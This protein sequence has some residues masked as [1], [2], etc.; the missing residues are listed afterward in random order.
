MRVALHEVL[1]DG[2]SYRHL[3]AAWGVPKSTIFRSATGEQP[4]DP[5]LYKY[6]GFSVQKTGDVDVAGLRAVA[7]QRGSDK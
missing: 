3:E 7:H 4:V 2:F 5:R 1:A 6:L